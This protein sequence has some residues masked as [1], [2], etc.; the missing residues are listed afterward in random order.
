MDESKKR[1]NSK[2]YFRKLKIIRIEQGHD[3]IYIWTKHPGWNCEYSFC[4]L[5]SEQVKGQTS[6]GNWNNLSSDS[7]DII[8]G[9]LSSFIISHNGILSA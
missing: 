2:N 6:S 8:R 4:L 3:N 1:N 9:K 5:K 7:A